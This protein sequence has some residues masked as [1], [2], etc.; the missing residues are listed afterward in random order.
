[1]YDL[2]WTKLFTIW[3]EELP[4]EHILLSLSIALSFGGGVV[5]MLNIIVFEKFSKFQSFVKQTYI[6]VI[7]QTF[8]NIVAHCFIYECVQKLTMHVS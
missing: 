5:C 2:G 8:S 3:Q 1:M 7:A 6:F 4:Y